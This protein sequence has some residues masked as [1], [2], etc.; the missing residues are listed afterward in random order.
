MEEEA[1][2]SPGTRHGSVSASGT[3]L[4]RETNEKCPGIKKSSFL[5]HIRVRKDLL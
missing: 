4:F 5:I 2:D 1:A 3:F